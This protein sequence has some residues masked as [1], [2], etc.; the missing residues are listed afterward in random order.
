MLKRFYE[1]LVGTRFRVGGEDFIKT[2]E[3]DF[4]KVPLRYKRSNSLNLNNN[5]RI[6]MGSRVEVEVLY[7]KQH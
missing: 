3:A 4:S 7:E 2:D 6:V 5:H 1:I